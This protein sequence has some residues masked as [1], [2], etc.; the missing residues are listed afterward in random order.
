MKVLVIGSGGR[1][2]AI[3]WK[4]AQSTKVG[5]IFVAPGNGGTASE[6][7]VKNVPISVGDKAGLLDF[8]LKEGIALTVVGPEAPLAAGIVD[9]FTEA[10]LKI[11]GPVKKAARIEAS[12]S[13]SKEIMMQAGVPTASYRRFTDADEAKAWVIE[14]GVPIVIK[15][16][17]LA[18]GKGVTVAMS[19]SEALLAIDDALVKKVFGDAGSSVVIEDYLD[20]EEL[21]YMV[22]ADGTTVVPM[23]TSQDHKAVFDGDKGPNTGGM[24]AYSPGP[25]MS[26]FGDLNGLTATP[27]VKALSANTPYRG[28]L[29]A[30]LMVGKTGLKVLEYNCR[31]GDPETEVIL[32][33]LKSDFLDMIMA[34]V[35]GRLSDIHVEWSGDPAVCVVMASGGYPGSYKTGYPIEGI[36]RADR[37]EGVKVFH[38]GTVYEDGVV[39][40]AGGRV[41]TVSATGKDFK[42]A[43]DRVYA[44][45]NLITFKDAHY[46]K[47]IGHRMIARYS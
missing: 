46:R 1:E 37:L 14:K 45:V 13:F 6:N 11:F 44:A 24:G 15:A 47:D 9:A 32:P 8:A 28:V 41:L 29:Y 42:E 31:F 22:V 26:R 36:E 33:R 40:T 34:A 23:A 35:D 43:L 21:S 16:D 39:K 19:D 20:G 2:H 4:L 38:S 10:G 30:G 5:Q 27:V 3:A 7:K 18:A 12:K 17:G 25:D